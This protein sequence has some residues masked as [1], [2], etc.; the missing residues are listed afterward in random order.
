[1]L[2]GIIG[3]L[4]LIQRRLDAGNINDLDRFL[5]AASASAQ[6]AAA[7]THRLLAFARQQSL[8]SK[9]QD[10]NALITGL[11]DMLRRTLGE[12]IVLETALDPGLWPVLTDKNQLESAIVNL[13]INSRDAMPNGGKV[14]IATSVTRFD[15]GFALLNQELEAGDYVAISVSDT[16]SGMPAD[17][18]EKAFEPFFTTKPIGQGTGLGLSMIYGFAKQSGGHVRL[19]SK[20]G[21]GTTVTLY[22]RRAVPVAAQSSVKPKTGAPCGHGETVLVVEDDPWIRILITEV[23]GELGYRYIEASDAQTAIPHLQSG[24]TIDLLVPDVGLPNMNGRQLAEIARQHRPELKI[25]FITGYAEKATVRG[26]SLS[27]GT[28]IMIKPFALDALGSK[29][30]ELIGG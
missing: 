3:S 19:D 8:D 28:E 26:D 15:E 6:R 24:Q 29:I 13:A 5:N 9:P 12:S 18:I 2:Q 16:G 14:T 10:V 11:E 1:M 23:L 17:V 21:I 25:L 4:D 22:L 27:P 20:V 7:L 30:R